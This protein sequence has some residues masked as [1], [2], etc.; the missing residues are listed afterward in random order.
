M[1]YM[2]HPKHG[3]MP[4]YTPQEIE[5]N[6]KNGWVLDGDNQQNL[7]AQVVP[8]IEAKSFQE[9]STKTPEINA[10]RANAVDAYFSKFGK[11]P[12]HRL[13]TENILKAIHANGG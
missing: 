12:H 1:K 10:E 8:A 2:S 9:T 13:S 3:R 4:V 11:K 6:Q 5:R 7:P